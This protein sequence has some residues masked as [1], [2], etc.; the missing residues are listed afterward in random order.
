MNHRLT[1]T[2]AALAL[3]LAAFA[4]TRPAPAQSAGGKGFFSSLKLGQMVELAYGDNSTGYYI[5]TYDD[6]AKKGLMV[7][8]VVDL[9]DDYI[10]LHIDPAPNPT[11]IWDV[12]IPT[13]SV[14]SM[15]HVRMAK[16]K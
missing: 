5:R 16:K 8:K 10:T 12:R 2:F 3:A 7:Y 4:A 1:A 6:P 15:F 11:E 13:Q 14:I 9:Q